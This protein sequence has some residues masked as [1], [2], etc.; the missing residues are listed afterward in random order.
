VIEEREG[1]TD[2]QPN[3]KGVS[4]RMVDGGYSEDGYDAPKRQEG[5]KNEERWLRDEPYNV[6]MWMGPERI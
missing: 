1:A 2:G 3:T 4:R 6:I 5:T